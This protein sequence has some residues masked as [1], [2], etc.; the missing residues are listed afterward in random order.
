MSKEKNNKEENKGLHIGVVSQQRELLVSFVKYIEEK[1]D[2]WR[3]PINEYEIDE[4]LETNC[5]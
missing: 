4:Y 5:G 3:I 2:M 1:T